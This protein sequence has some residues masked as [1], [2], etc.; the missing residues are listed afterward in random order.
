MNPSSLM[1]IGE[2]V[3][4]S[5]IHLGIH[6]AEDFLSRSIYDVYFQMQ[7]VNKKWKNKMLLYALFGAVNNINCLHMDSILKK[8][9]CNEYNEFLKNNE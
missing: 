2:K 7:F 5:L 4:Q 6:T 1:N 9:I 8:H 3:E